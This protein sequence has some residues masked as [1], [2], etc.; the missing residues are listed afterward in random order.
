VDAGL[1]GQDLTVVTRVL[2]QQGGPP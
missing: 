2:Q 1:G